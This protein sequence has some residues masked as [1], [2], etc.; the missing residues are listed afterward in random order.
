MKNTSSNRAIFGSL[1]VYGLLAFGFST[2]SLVLPNS[3]LVGNPLEVSGLSFEHVSGHIIFGIVAGI[4]TFSLRYS[5]LCGTFTI[6]LDFDHWLQFLNLEMIPR[7]AHSIPYGL[8]VFLVILIIFGKK[9]LRIPA[10]SLGA[11]F[12]H[13]SY[14]VFHT[15][16]SRFPLFVPFSTEMFTLSGLDWLIMEI[17]SFGVI[18]CLTLLRKKHTKV[19][20]IKK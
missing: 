9:D 10:I 5:I 19:I 11:V 16:S 3:F 7:M 4:A 15:G 8:L 14:D 17:I 20:Q 6:A 12:A 18:L 1:G 2:L 13:I